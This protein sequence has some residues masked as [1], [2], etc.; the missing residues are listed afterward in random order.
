MENSKIEWTTHTFN[1]WIG[2]TKVSPGCANCY[3]ETLMDKRFGRA[4][5]G[6]ENPR[7]L[8]SRA[9]WAKPLKWNR[10]YAEGDIMADPPV[11]RPRVFCASLSDWLDWKAPVEWRVEL[12][13]LIEK[14][15]FLNWLMLTKRPES[16]EA[17]MMEACHASP[18]AGKWLNGDAPH[19]VWMGTSVEDQA[20]AN[21]RI[22]LLLE[23]PARI[24][25]LSCEP[26]LGP[27]SIPDAL[28][29]KIGSEGKTAGIHWVI[30]GGESGP[31]SR[32]MQ[33]EWARQLRDDCE[34]AHVA[35][36]FK[37]WGGV[38][39]KA[40]GRELDGR[41]HDDIPENAKVADPKDSV[42]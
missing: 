32:Q 5:W 42:H 23:I 37:Q 31:G 18:L 7:S 35:F 19:N 21:E 4:K 40:N 30:C 8:T 26:L 25:F 29:W 16:W 11:Q 12:L 14:T 2:C 34:E 33:P 3:A 17:R 36:L 41:T 10:D 15:P 28:P 27:V 13:R 22:P 24:R 20:R 1:P 6:D 38:D 39:K 9:E